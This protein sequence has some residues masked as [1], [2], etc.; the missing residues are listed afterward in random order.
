MKIKIQGRPEF[1]IEFT[2]ELT[3]ELIK[4]ALN[5]YD[6][7]CRSQASEGPLIR[8]KNM[9]TMFGESNEP[10]PISMTFRQLDTLCKVAESSTVG[11]VMDFRKSS[12][13]AFQITSEVIGFWSEEV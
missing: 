4:C 5:H 11:I 6:S 7:V 12:E 3:E 8:A 10:Y 1:T 9:T 2:K 13:K